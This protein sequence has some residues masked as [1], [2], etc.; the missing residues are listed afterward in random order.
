MAEGR[1]PVRRLAVATLIAAL[2]AAC[3]GPS[4]GNSA[5]SAASPPGSAGSAVTGQ[6]TV[7]AAASLKVA[8]TT[9]GKQFEAAHPGTDVVFSFGASS[10][11]AQQ[12]DQ[13]APADVFAS[14]STKNMDQVVSGGAAA[15]PSSFAEN[16]MEIAVPPANPAHVAT[17][18]D[19]A[20]KDVKVALC[21]AAVPCGATALEVFHSAGV[22]V[23]PVTQEADVKAT[24]SKVELG[25]VD[26]GVVY[27]TDVRAAGSK[28]EGV[29]IPAA[30]NASTTY[31]IAALTASNNAVT[32]QAFVDYV[33]SADGRAVLTAAGFAQP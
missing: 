30:I 9:L 16:V 24:L 19:L 7:F 28:V 2:L 5:G 32:A 27:V 25:E 17:V 15:S 13:G 3:G 20:R 23:T 29:E 33:L 4:I 14:A 11:L 21:Q 10:T 22:T 6:I 18:A 12:I 31:P 26:A 1:R 8:F